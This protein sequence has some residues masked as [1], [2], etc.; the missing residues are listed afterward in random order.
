MDLEKIPQELKPNSHFVLWREETRNGKLT[1]I[2]VNAHNRKA[3]VD[4]P[5][6]WATFEVAVATLTRNGKGLRGMGFVLIKSGPFTVIDLDHCR[7]P[8]T[9]IIEPWAQEIIDRL[10]SYTEISPSG[11]GVHIWL[12][13]KLPPGRR[14][15][16][17]FEAY[18]SDRYL[19]LTGHHLEGTPL[20]IEPRQTELEA[21]HVEIFGKPS[22]ESKQASGSPSKA[23][24][25]DIS[26]DDLLDKI[27]K[28]K[29]GGKFEMHCGNTLI[30]MQ[31]AGWSINMVIIHNL[32][33]TSPFV[34][35]WHFGPA[36]TQ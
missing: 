27:S 25:S 7:D 14:R 30:R 19:T 1:K 32:K 17:N 9:G 28:S 6:T 22:E 31:G 21:Q 33:Q 2:P 11:T 8:E 26:D 12:I 15:K 36:K 3:A 23:A 34:P 5:D 29:N 10:V 16:G 20:T 4:R 24:P 13:G 35:S 18:D